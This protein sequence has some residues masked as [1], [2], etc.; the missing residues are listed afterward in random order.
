MKERRKEV[1]KRKK[2]TKRGNKE[3]KQ[4]RDR[5]GISKEL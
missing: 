1:K 4:A 2:T 5:R 3:Q